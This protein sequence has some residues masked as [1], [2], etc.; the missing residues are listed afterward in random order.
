VIVQPEVKEPA[1]AEPEAEVK[2]E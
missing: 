1:V 2:H